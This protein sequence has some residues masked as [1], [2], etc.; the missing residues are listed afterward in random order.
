MRIESPDL[1]DSYTFD[2]LKH[3]NVHE[4]LQALLNWNQFPLEAEP[5][6]SPLISPLSF[7]DKHLDDSLILK[8]VTILP[9]LL[10]ALSRTVDLALD[11]LDD[12]PPLCPEFPS[13]FARKILEGS[14]DPVVGAISLAEIY[15]STT[16]NYCGTI[17]SALSI[18]T[19]LPTWSTF[20]VWRIDKKSDHLWKY[21]TV[22][23]SLQIDPMEFSTLS[24][25][26]SVRPLLQEGKE[27]TMLDVFKSLT[28]LGTWMIHTVS[29]EAE[30]LFREMDGIASKPFTS[31]TC[32]T[33]GSL[34]GP[35][36]SFDMFDAQHS[37][38]TIV[39]TAT[40]LPGSRTNPRA[41]KPGAPFNNSQGSAKT[42][43]KA[44]TRSLASESL[45]HK[46]VAPTIQTPNKSI[47]DE[48]RRCEHGHPTSADLVQHVRSF[49][50]LLLH[51]N[52]A[53]LPFS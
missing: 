13:A 23:G 2:E 15:Q 22:R 32:L 53:F 31:Q 35:H 12:L 21:D 4:E 7:H 52:D 1:P 19:C 6:P 28:K 26:D 50:L 46:S 33:K 10:S 42:R 45:L 49:L 8:R 25:L 14:D 27:C 41:R 17:A 48:R 30:R 3:L 37:P 39:V 36:I 16:A 51:V 43:K 44:V 38:W 18:T 24:F 9:S 29:D 34:S 20:L 40:K 47:S 11:S 5:D